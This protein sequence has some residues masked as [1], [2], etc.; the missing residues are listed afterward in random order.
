[1][2]DIYSQITYLHIISLLLP[3][4]KASVL[5]DL[6]KLSKN[7]QQTGRIDAFE[8]EIS[9]NQVSSMILTTVETNEDTH[10]ETNRPSASRVV[11]IDGMAVVNSVLK[12]NQMKTCQDFSNYFLEI[13]CSIAV[14][15]DEV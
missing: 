1:M 2:D 4:D 13:I 9:S 6:E 8:S 10:V 11:I 3:Y 7:S 14:S 12:K 5:H 15:Y